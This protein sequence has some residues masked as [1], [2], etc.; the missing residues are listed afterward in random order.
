MLSRG[1]LGPA[2]S[3]LIG[4]VAVLASATSTA[5]A[6]ELP[7]GFSDDVVFSGLDAPTALRFSPG[8]DRI[9]VAE[10]DGLIKVFDNLED[11]APT[12]F[13]V[14]SGEVFPLGDR[15]LLGIEVH[16]DFPD[17]PYVYALYTH[18]SNPTGVGP[19]EWDE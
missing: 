16:P 1:A 10:K 14:L 3:A 17:E 7:E 12:E 4:V 8:D 11:L 2:I 18:D 15:G 13:A 6:A 19:E 5:Q 9:F